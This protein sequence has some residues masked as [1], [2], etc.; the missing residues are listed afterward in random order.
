MI[1][2]NLK[3]TKQSKTGL[4]TEFVNIKTNRTFSR[5]HVL[6]QIDK[7]N[8]N[9]ENYQHVHRKNGPDY[10]RSKPDNK[11]NNNIE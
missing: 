2:I 1:Y 3:A 4:N 8:P 11:L 5:A 10:V 6:E 7:G 9:Y